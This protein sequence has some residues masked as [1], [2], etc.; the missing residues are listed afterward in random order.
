M[1]QVGFIYKNDET[2]LFGMGTIR[3]SRKGL[4]YILKRK[5]QMEHR[6]FMFCNKRRVAAVKWQD[7]KLVMVLSTCYSPKEVS[8]MKQNSRDDASSISPCPA[9]VAKYN[10]ITRGW[11]SLDQR[12]YGNAV[13][14]RSLKW[15]YCLLYCM[16]TLWLWTDLSCGTAIAVISLTSSHS[17]FFSLGSS[18]SAMS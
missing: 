17:D 4:P 6:D 5:D 7:N 14:I 15:W 3:A 12:W 11:D 1:H 13:W 16:C 10:A 9:T 8:W 18:Q 2:G